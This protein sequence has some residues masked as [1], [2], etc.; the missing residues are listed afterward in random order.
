MN[1]FDFASTIQ[2]ISSVKLMCKVYNCLFNYLFAFGHTLVA[3]IFIECQ[4][5]QD[6][7]MTIIVS[8]LF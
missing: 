5:I 4:T 6:G 3:Y 8:L 2:E 7:I 1:W